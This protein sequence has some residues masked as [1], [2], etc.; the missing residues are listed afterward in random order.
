M[1]VRAASEDDR[2]WS[3]G[4][5]PGS[6]SSTGSGPA[7]REAGI[8]VE[9]KVLRMGGVGLAGLHVQTGLRV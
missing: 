7:I 3:E 6:P 9:T 1:R 8:Q 4:G 5:G 2:L